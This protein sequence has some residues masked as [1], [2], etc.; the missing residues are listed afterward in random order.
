MFKV[1]RFHKKLSIILDSAMSILS[2]KIFSV[3]VIL[4]IF[5]I[6]FGEQINAKADRFKFTALTSTD[7]LSSNTVYTILKDRYGLMWFGTDDGLNKYD[8][9][10]FTVYRHDPADPASLRSN[11]ISALH[12]DKLGQIWVGTIQGS[13][14]LYN[15]RKDTFI[16]INANESVT[17]ITSDHRGEIWVA[18]TAGLLMV[19]PATHKITRL[20]Q[21]PGVADQ[22]AN[23]QILSLF[24]D[25]KKQMW[26]GTQTG[27]YRFDFKTSLFL[28]ISYEYGLTK[29]DSGSQ[30]KTIADDKLGNIWIGTSNGLHKLT[31][32]GN[33]IQTF[34]FLP[35]NE[36]TI[37]SNMIYAIAAENH[38]SLWICTDGG[39]NLMDI[40][41]GNVTRYAPDAR[42]PF[43]LTNKSVRSILIDKQGIFWLGTY[44]G[45][46][47]KYDRNFT[48]FGLKRS[49]PYDPYSLSA[50][51]VTSFAE[52]TD[53]DLFVGT[54][55]GGLNLYHRKTNLFT[56]VPVYPKNKLASSGLAIMSLE[57]S[58]PDRL[59]IGTFQD[60]LFALNPKNGQYQQFKRGQAASSLGNNDIF[61]MTTDTKG[62]LWI[63]T[64]GGGVNLFDPRTQ[65]FTRF[66]DPTIPLQKREIPLN[67]YIRAIHED[68]HGNIWIG[69]HGT[70]VAIYNPELRKSVLLDKQSSNLP[71]N[72]VLA[73]HEDSKGNIWVGTRGEGL[74]RFNVK[75]G[76]F[77][78][79]A[80]K[81]GL[82]NGV[83][84]KILED[85]Q[86]RIWVSTN[87]G[88]SYLDPA[89][90]SFV[91][92]TQ[93]NGLQ[94]N[95]FVL[96]A[97]IRTWDKLLFFGGIQGF[98]YLNTNTLRQNN[99]DMPVILKELRAGNKIITPSDSLIIEE[100]ISIAK[101]IHL[102]YK[103]NF[104]IS[105]AALNYS[106]PQ[107]TVFRYRLEGLDG[108]WHQAGYSK[109][110]SY[111]NLSPGTYTFNVQARNCK[112]IWNEPGATIQVIVR[113]PFY[114][115]VC[116]YLFYFVVFFG[117]LF[118]TRHKGI[119]RL[120]NKFR[121][122]QH[123]REIERQREVDE[124]KIK[125]LTNLSHEL[126]TPISL[127][128]A[129][130]DH[131]LSRTAPIDKAQYVEGIKRNAKRLLNLVDQL[132]D[133]KSLQE[134]ESKLDS[135]YGEIVSFIKENGRILPLSI[136]DK[137]Y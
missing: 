112:G 24:E 124:M 115:T 61:C 97:G 20:N 83:V 107:Q 105:Y 133:F 69:S 52:K 84:H 129:P 51:F 32:D 29:T 113:P 1:C 120:K 104:S 118:L 4:S 37:S 78:A 131:L 137:W 42:T 18:T 98:N 49:D 65:L 128:L 80:D 95:T 121:Q 99:N 39:L 10:E 109:T 28:P 16:H 72:V 126:R 90:K 88:V 5:S 33:P 25:S 108:E 58:S 56:K 114:M 45:G 75:T 48:I 7:G 26:I 135:H 38:Q 87:Q 123:D 11:D 47:N 67:G 14:H 89:T 46:I 13:L 70:G 73:I 119:Q 9:T 17:A 103:Q 71:D 125:F 19:N 43:S 136:S 54:D 44:K 77:S 35:H 60:G 91:N 34:R 127:I 134:H 12:E 66:F 111:T 57:I 53:G 59:W 102:E 101:S 122:E 76:K 63:G 85:A 130:L 21:R 55:G 41:T 92:Y 30:V 8:G 27:L 116:A 31:A 50:P 106:D 117:L 3:L 68:K 62:R 132:L 15:R 86:G 64:N 36:K 100:H 93:H 6:G 2:K 81:E 40:S 79:F 23:G 110:A 74:A 94:N 96:G 22:I 82:A